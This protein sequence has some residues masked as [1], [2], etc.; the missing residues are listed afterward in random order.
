MIRDASLTPHDG[1]D[2]DTITGTWVNI[3]E[4]SVLVERIDIAAA[5][6]DNLRVQIRG[7]GENG[8]VDWGAVTAPVY[9]NGADNQ[10]AGFHASWQLPAADITVATAHNRGVLVF[11]TYTRFKD[12]SGRP[13]Y[14]SKEFFRKEGG[15]R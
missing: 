2:M 5:E 15:A 7:T 10:P 13:H 11:H 6:G 9:S 12:D 8:P 14:F 4:D 3:K 1:L